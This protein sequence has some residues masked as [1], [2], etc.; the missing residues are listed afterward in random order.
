MRSNL[1][2]SC[3]VC[4][5]LAKNPARIIKEKIV[6]CFTK[7]TDYGTVIQA[8]SDV[9]NLDG[10]GVIVARNP[11]Y[12]L[13][14]CDGFP[15]LAVDYELGTDILFYI[16]SSRYITVPTYFHLLVTIT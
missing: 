11:G 13:N 12:Q 15:C 2:K 3:R 6:L 16:R 1:Y 10:Y 5:D 14:P 9:F 7:S 4:E 8:A